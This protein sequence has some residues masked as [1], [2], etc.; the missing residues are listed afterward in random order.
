MGAPEMQDLDVGGPLLFSGVL[1]VSH[2]LVGPPVTALR[3]DRRA[4]QAIGKISRRADQGTGKNG[5]FAKHGP[6]CSL[7]P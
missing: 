5:R 2:L 4:D 6:P 1:G 7:R 3:T